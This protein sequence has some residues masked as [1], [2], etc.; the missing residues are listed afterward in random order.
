[1]HI[2]TRSCQC[3]KQ[4]SKLIQPRRYYNHTLESFKLHKERSKH[5]WD[6]DL[7]ILNNAPY[8]LSIDLTKNRIFEVKNGRKKKKKAKTKKTT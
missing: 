6:L 1:M 3:H 5:K 2:V 4:L 7:S 8:N